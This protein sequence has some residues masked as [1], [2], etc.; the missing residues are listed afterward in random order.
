MAKRMTIRLVDELASIVSK[1]SRKR[2]ISIN[3]L[4]TEMAWEFVEHWET[5][6][7]RKIF[8]ENGNITTPPKK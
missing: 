4:I 8:F 3:A 2:G 1:I 5:N 7:E 6:Q